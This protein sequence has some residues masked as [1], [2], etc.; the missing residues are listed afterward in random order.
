MAEHLGYEPHDPAG[1]GSGNTRNGSYAKTVTTE[2]GTVELRMP[3]DR[4]GDVRAGDGPEASTTPRW[5]C[6][7]T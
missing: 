3:R 7:A 6:R 4:D 2:I 5:P 1:R